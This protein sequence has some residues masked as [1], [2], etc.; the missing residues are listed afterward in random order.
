V[1][2][3]NSLHLVLQILISTHWPH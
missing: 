3:F 1:K 2:S